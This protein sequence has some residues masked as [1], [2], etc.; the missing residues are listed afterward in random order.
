MII[1]FRIFPIVFL[2]IVFGMMSLSPVQAQWRNLFNLANSEFNGSNIRGTQFGKGLEATDESGNEFRFE[3]LKGKI[4]LIYFGFTLCPDVCPTTLIQLS[5]LKAMLT[6]DE[7][8][9]VQVY[10]VTLDPERDTPERL[11]EYIAYFDPSFK[12]LIG[13]PSQLAQMTKSFNVFYSKVPTAA[14]QYTMEHSAYVFVLDQEADSV[15]LFREGMDLEEMLSD[16]KKL[17]AS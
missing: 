3:D 1:F 10:F 16:L 15:L 7:A 17:L 12:G 9:K 8:E 6:E 13:N 5:Q 4:S 14:G 2:S 11:K